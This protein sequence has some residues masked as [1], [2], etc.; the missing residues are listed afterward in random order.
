MNVG[1]ANKK[2]VP[3]RALLRKHGWVMSIEYYETKEK[4][5]KATLTC[6]DQNDRAQDTYQMILDPGIIYRT[7]R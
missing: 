2:Q 6:T 7:Y 1:N 4:L 5:N 3:Q